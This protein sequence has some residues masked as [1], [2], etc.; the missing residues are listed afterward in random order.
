MTRAAVVLVALAV[1]GCGAGSEP[2]AQ[3]PPTE[4]RVA[5]RPEG[6][7]GPERTRT[8]RCRAPGDAPACALELERLEPVPPTRACIEI[9]GGAATATVTGRLRNQPVD[10]RFALS[11]GCEIARWKAASALLGPPPGRP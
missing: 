5:V 2:E 9:Y 11:N 8:I 6:P 7:K 10:A 3:A 1:A 4:L